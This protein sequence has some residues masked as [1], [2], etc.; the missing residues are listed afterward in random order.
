MQ[1]HLQLVWLTSRVCLHSCVQWHTPV[2][3]CEGAPGKV[4][5]TGALC[6]ATPPPP[7]LS[8]VTLAPPKELHTFVKRPVAFLSA[9]KPTPLSWKMFFVGGC[10]WMWQM[11]FFCFNSMHFPLLF[12]H[13]GGASWWQDRLLHWTVEKSG[14]QS[15]SVQEQVPTAVIQRFRLDLF[16]GS[17]SRQ[18]TLK[19]AL[20]HCHHLMA[21]S[22]SRTK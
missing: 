6:S 19:Y 9:D 13:H 4:A 22:K 21:C 3:G 5:A 20:S 8:S 11:S 16:N 17:I 18:L 2:Y 7:P 12:L 15:D 1:A 14:C 10:G